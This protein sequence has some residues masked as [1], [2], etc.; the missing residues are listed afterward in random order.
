MKIAMLTRYGP[1]GANSRYRLL[2]YIPSF[3]RAGHSV[4][5]RPMLDD[6]Y[7]QA[8]YASGRRSRW[9]VVRGYLR[10]LAQLRGLGAIRHRALRSG[11]LSVSSSDG[12]AAG[13]GLLRAAGGGL[14]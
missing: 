2:Q 11:V 13:S 7:L 12:R 1:M 14:R 5:V 8:L 9:Q 4:E 6:A 3:E 10:R